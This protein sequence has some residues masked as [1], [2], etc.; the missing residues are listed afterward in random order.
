[1]KTYRLV[2]SGRVQGVG[3]RYFA[4]K[5]ALALNI[6]GWVKNNFNKTVE[7]AAQCDEKSL[8]IFIN[9]LKK[10]PLMSKVDHIQQEI[11]DL[12]PQATFNITG[13]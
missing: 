2:I 1:M 5:K 12:E 9:E 4:Q 6:T 10:G 3:Y 8:E 13:W 7:I 11:I